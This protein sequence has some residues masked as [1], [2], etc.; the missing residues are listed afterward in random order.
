MESLGVNVSN[1]WVSPSAVSGI[2]SGHDVVIL[3]HTA[4]SQ[5]GVIPT[6]YGSG[7]PVIAVPVGGLVEQIDPG[8]SGLLTADRSPQAVA[9]EI[10]RLAEDRSL[11]QRLR[12]GVTQ[13]RQQRSMKS[14]LTA[15]SAVG[16]KGISPRGYPSLAGPTKCKPS[17]SVVVPVYNRSH[18]IARA[19]NSVLAQSVTPDE[20]IVV[21]DGSTDNLASALEPFS[22]RVRIIRHASNMGAGGARNTGVS[23]ATGE[24]IAFLDSDDAWT[25]HKLASQMA[26]MQKHALSTSCTGFEII[27]DKKSVSRIAWRPYGEILGVSD[28]AW[29]CYISPGSTL[30]SSRD[31]FLKSGAFDDRFQRFEDW[32]L[33]LRMVETSDNAFGFLNKLLATIYLER[34]IGSESWLAAL[35]MLQEKHEGSLKERSKSLPR[36]LRSGVAFNRASVFATQRNW[37][38]VTRELSKA[39]LFAP[40]GNWPF[41]VILS[42][43]LRTL[44]IRM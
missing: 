43:R 2:F 9:A 39:I 10:R 35:D 38:A 25:Q 28:F 29:G 31:F 19:I 26:F 22:D 4:A 41:R 42:E 37:E 40:F 34:K 30:L 24:L 11:L 36:K 1:G 27:T 20:I 18:S 16:L 14:F 32:D 12:I 17:I 21:D 8:V 7:V 15:I 33:M 44:P 5:S 13:G 3:T 6:A 23:A